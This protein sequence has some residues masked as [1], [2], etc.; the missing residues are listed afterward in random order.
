MRAPMSDS[1]LVR[2][3]LPNC[4]LIAGNE[5]FSFSRKS[6]SMV[7]SEEAAKTIQRKVKG[8]HCRRI[9][10]VEE[11]VRTSYPASPLHPFDNGLTST[12][13]VSGKILAPFFSARYK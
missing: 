5:P 1:E 10:A 4:E 7:P 8:R 3:C 6:S 12:T 2:T 13:W 9:A 11:T